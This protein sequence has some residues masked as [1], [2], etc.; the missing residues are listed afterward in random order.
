MIFGFPLCLELGYLT[1]DSAGYWPVI[2]S[3]SFGLKLIFK[4][5]FMVMLTE[6]SNYGHNC[7][8][9]GP[10]VFGKLLKAGRTHA[11]LSMYT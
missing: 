6:T 10:A 8:L 11:L 3:G 7:K 2:Q 1:I 9:Q 5:S 4:M